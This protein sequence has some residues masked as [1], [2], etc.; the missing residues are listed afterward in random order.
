M[1]GLGSSVWVLAPAFQGAETAR[2]DLGSHRLEFGGWLTSLVLIGIIAVPI[3]LILHLGPEL[4]LGT[5]V[6]SALATDIPLLIFVY[7]RLIMPG[8]LTWAELGLQP[9]SLG[10]IFSMGITAGIAGLIVIGA[11]GTLLSQ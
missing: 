10:Y 2:R 9:L 6:I 1:L 3:S 5:F 8:A 11:I 7:V 4:T